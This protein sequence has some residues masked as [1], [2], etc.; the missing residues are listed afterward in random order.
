MGDGEAEAA[1]AACDDDGPF[2]KR[3]QLR[4]LHSRQHGLKKKNVSALP[5]QN[6]YDS[7]SSGCSG[8]PDRFFSSSLVCSATGRPDDTGRGSCFVGWDAFGRSAFPSLSS[9]FRPGAVLELELEL[10]MGKDVESGRIV[11]AR[12]RG[13]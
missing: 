2:T 10:K 6:K 4:R 9:I 13:R 12:V 8:N 3:K 5:V 11:G 1:A 7:L